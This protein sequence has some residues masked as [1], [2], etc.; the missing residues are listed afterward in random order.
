M[1]NQTVI[2]LSEPDLKPWLQEQSKANG[3]SLS[4]LITN[5]LSAIKQQEI[6][7]KPNPF[8]SFEGKLT[9]Q[10]IEEFDLIMKN[11]KKDF[12]S[13]PESYYENMFK[14]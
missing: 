14:D 13:K 12:V 7:Q 10:E 4:R 5:Y 3:V 11:I 1:S 9:P 2:Y 6:K 8:L